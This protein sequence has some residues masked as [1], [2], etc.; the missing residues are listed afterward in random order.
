MRK[1]TIVD[2]L[3][4]HGLKATSSR[5]EL[6]SR[7]HDYPSAIPYSKLQQHLAF[8]D[9]VTLYRTIEALVEKGLI[10]QAYREQ[11]EIYYALCDKNCNPG[12]HHDEHIHF[13]CKSC[14]MVQ[15]LTLRE[16][17]QI[18]MEGHEL[19]GLDIRAEGICSDC[20]EVPL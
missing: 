11:S 7:M 6:L 1:E 3:H 4:T 5:I 10:H 19:Q 16:E 8:V 2:L 13:K 17:I 9:R 15:C 20:K 18:S 12:S 14:G